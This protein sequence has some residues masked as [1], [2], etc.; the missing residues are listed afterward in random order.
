MPTLPASWRAA[1]AGRRRDTA[2]G[3]TSDVR[4][5]TVETAFLAAARRL[6]G[7]VRGVGVALI[8]AFGLLTMPSQALPAG[9]AVFGLVLVGSAVDCWVG[10]S[11]RAAPLALAF[12]V[13]RVV[14]VCVMLQCSGAP[15]N[16]W[17]LNVLTTTAITLQWEWPAPV[18]A[19]VTAGLLAVDLAVLGTGDAGSLVPRL[20]FECVLARLGFLLLLRSSRRTDEVRE[21]RSALARAEALARARHQRQRE[22]LALLHDTASSTFLQ[23]AVRADS[24][25]AQVARYARHDLAILTGAAGTPAGS[26]SAVD[27]AASLHAVVARS[28]LAIELRRQGEALVP[29][30]VALALLRAVREGLANVERH[31]HVDAATLTVRTEQD[32]VAVTVRDAGAGF[33]PDEVPRSCRG[34]RGSIVERMRAVGGDATVISAPGNGTTIRLVWPG[35]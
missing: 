9:L 3:G 11:G 26:D 35:G 16:P 12:A 28:R 21:H 33:A 5:R 22:Y 32:L 4:Y 17:A 8:S 34:I 27:L 24:D 25:P 10:F 13:A 2:T 1:G 31:A 19:P 6:A 30:S 23:I 7:P 20:L 15:P 14:A 29:A 18:A